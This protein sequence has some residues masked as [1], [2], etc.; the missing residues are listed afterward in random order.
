MERIRIAVAVLTITLSLNACAAKTVPALS[1][2]QRGRLGRVGVVLVETKPESDMASPTPLGGVGGGV[3][4][5]AKGMGIGVLSGAGCFATLGYVPL[6]CVSAV[7]TPYWVGRGAVEGAMNAMPEGQ[8]RASLAALEAAIN[9]VDRSLIADAIEEERR[10]R[11]GSATIASPT[12]DI[13]TVA[14]VTLL[15]LGLVRQQSSSSA[16]TLKLSV[17]DV[18]P[19]L[20]L[21]AEARLRLLSAAAN[22]VLFDTTY[23]RRSPR[24]A[25]FGEWGSDDAAEFR[26]ARDEALRALGRDVADAIFGA[27]PAEPAPPAET[28]STPPTDEF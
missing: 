18:D 9:D 23:V 2:E 26:T 16:D 10:R 3:L 6:L 7:M 19:M 27:A 22:T 1:E 21:V 15:R 28:A 25:R 8:R 14:E 13:D 5:A 20:D 24:W 17:P 11:P 4:G 12:Q